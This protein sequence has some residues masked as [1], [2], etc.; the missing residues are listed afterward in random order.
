MAFLLEK[1]EGGYIVKTALN[2]FELPVFKIEVKYLPPENCG[3]VPFELIFP[4]CI[5]F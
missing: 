5:P 2:N 1:T 4:D 3:P